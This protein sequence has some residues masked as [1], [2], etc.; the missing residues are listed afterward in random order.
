MQ[1]ISHLW[2]KPCTD[3]GIKFLYLKGNSKTSALE[4]IL[5]TGPNGGNPVTIIEIEMLARKRNGNRKIK[6]NIT[7]FQTKKFKVHRKKTRIRKFRE[8]KIF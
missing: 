3:K 6:E 2:T 4:L 1:I 5:N 8:N 7:K